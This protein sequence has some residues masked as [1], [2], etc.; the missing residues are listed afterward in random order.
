MAIIRNSNN[1]N[2]NSVFSKNDTVIKNKNKL[3]WPS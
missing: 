3:T 1:K 2:K